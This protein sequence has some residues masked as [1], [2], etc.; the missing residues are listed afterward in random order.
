MRSLR[1]LI[2]VVFAV[3]LF[4]TSQTMAVTRGTMRDATGAVVLCTG[5]GPITVL[6]DDDGQP[7][8]PPKICPDCAMSVFA[9]AGSAFVLSAPQSRV[10]PLR[11]DQSVTL[12]RT[13]QTLTPLARGP[14]V[15]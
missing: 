11:A 12:R 15:V 6:I 4:A 13:A 9:D 1:P 14:P 7:V 8:G 10:T 5:T 2:A 3:L